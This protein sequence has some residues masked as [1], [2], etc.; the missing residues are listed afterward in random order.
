M[1]TYLGACHCGDLSLEYRTELPVSEWPLRECQCSF[2]RKHMMLSTSDPDG[3]VV[4]RSRTASLN[5]Y[6]FATGVTDFLVCPR[7]GVYVGATVMDDRWMVINARVMDCAAALSG[8][9]AEPRVY[10]N[11][12]GAERIEHRQRM[13]ARCRIDL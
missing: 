13:W 9:T 8:R 5:R 6:R 3:E 4:V 7:C 1:A 11:E 2:C 12:S 10:D